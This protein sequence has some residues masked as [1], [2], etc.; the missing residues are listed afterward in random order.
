MSQHHDPLTVVFRSVCIP[1]ANALGP[2]LVRYIMEQDPEQQA[3]HLLPATPLRTFHDMVDGPLAWQRFFCDPDV[4][5]ARAAWSNLVLDHTVNITDA[6]S[7]RFRIFDEGEGI[8]HNLMELAASMRQVQDEKVFKQ[9]QADRAY[10]Q[11]T[12]CCVIHV[13]ISHMNS[14]K[15]RFS[16][17]TEQLG[18]EHEGELNRLRRFFAKERTL[19]LAASMEGLSVEECSHTEH[20]QLRGLQQH[21]TLLQSE[22]SRLQD[23]TTKLLQEHSTLQGQ[24]EI[25]TERAESAESQLQEAHMQ[26]A[27]E[28]MVNITSSDNAEAAARVREQFEE[29]QD[30]IVM[31]RTRSDNYHR[32]NGDLQKRIEELERENM[33][34][35]LRLAAEYD[36]QNGGERS[37]G[38][39]GSRRKRGDLSAGGSRSVPRTGGGMSSV[40][41]EL[42]A[43]LDQVRGALD[44]TNKDIRIC[45]LAHE[46]REHNTMLNATYRMVEQEELLEYQDKE[47]R[48]LRRAMYI[49]K[50]ELA[51]TRDRHLLSDFEDGRRRAQ[52]EE[53]ATSSH[54]A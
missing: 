13:L 12:A 11:L 19:L 30:R 25:N 10:D 6:F 22:V 50:C 31:E 49:C 18:A 46:E 8:L 35:R 34:G 17:L 4:V 3:G 42:R 44:A 26:L 48:E 51:I 52:A 53:A 45:L 1:N 9:L 5:E 28:R 7:H 15:G 20:P 54:P 38:G 36:R 39:L 23:L 14:E 24:S 29:W 47:N 2:I 16:Y 27:M 33:D 37:T 40:E 32:L 41:I 21:N 43:Q